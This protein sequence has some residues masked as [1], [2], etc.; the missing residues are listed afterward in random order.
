MLHFLQLAGDAA[1][2]KDL[3]SNL[4]YGVCAFVCLQKGLHSNNSKIVHECFACP[5]SFVVDGMY[6]VHSLVSLVV[7]M[8]RG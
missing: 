6:A 7:V 2:E 3:C 8:R 1:P 4:A 5:L